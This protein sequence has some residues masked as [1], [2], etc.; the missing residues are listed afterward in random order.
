MLLGGAAAAWS[1][2]G[3][4]Q[5]ATLPVV[6]FVHPGSSDTM[7]HLSAAF[8]KGLGES[9][10]VEGQSVR[11]EYRFAENQPERLPVLVA[12][13]LRLPVIAI[14]GPATSMRVAQSATSTIPILFV[15]GSDPVT[16][17]LVASINRPGGNVTGVSL[18]ASE[19]GSKRLGL[20]REV[21][22][23]SGTIAY[24]MNPN[25]DEREV[26]LV[27][28]QAAARA[29]GQ[30]ILILNAGTEDEFVSAFTQLVREKAT[31]LIVAADPFFN[32]RRE[33][34]VTLA[35]QHS[36]PAIYEQREYS[37]AGGLMSYGTSITDA[38]RQL[39][40]YAGRV[41]KGARPADLPVLQPIR[42]Q[43]VINLRT[44][45]ALGV[46]VPLHLQQLADEVIE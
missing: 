32:S 18:F 5:Q 30:K 20:I 13:L 39:G 26:E 25:Y 9:G 46:D 22:P 36:I 4:A 14:A 21:M 38:Y 42:F 10:F 45:R 44:A 6:G 34:L 16:R 15:S 1:R 41:L 8:R 23:K 17:S 27:A 33:R 35:A 37:E 19:M 2:T 3:H 43:L 12:E 31:A 11:I 29:M 28:I 40:D 24:L 7:A